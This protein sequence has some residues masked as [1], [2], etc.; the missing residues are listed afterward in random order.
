MTV[1][2]HLTIGKV[3]GTTSKDRLKKL[4]LIEERKKQ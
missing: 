1:S 3:H 4:I 2:I